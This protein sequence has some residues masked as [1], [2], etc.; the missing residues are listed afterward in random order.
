MSVVGVLV[1]GERSSVVG[2]L[3]EEGASTYD[4]YGYREGRYEY[5]NRGCELNERG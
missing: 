5:Q 1:V 3:L 4:R 2:F